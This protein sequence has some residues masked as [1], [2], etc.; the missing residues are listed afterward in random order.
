MVKKPLS[1]AVAVALGGISCAAQADNIW[2]IYEKSLESDPVILRA[3]AQR[4]EAFE[5]ITEARAPLLPQISVTGQYTDTSS[6]RDFRE[7]DGTSATVGLTQ[8]IYR[9]ESWITLDLAEKSA[10]QADVNYNLQLQ[11]LMLRVSQAYFDVLQ[12]MDD[13]EFIA[14]EKRAIERQL[15]QTKQR[16]AVGLTAITDVHEAQAEYDRSVADEIVQLNVLENSYEGLRVLTGLSHRDL[17]VL[18]TE[19]FSPTKPQP[20]SSDGWQ[21]IATDQNLSLAVSRV[22]TDIAKQ[23]IDL[24][25]AGH[26]PTFS[27]FAQHDTSN[28][29]PDFDSGRPDSYDDTTIGVQ[30]SVPIYTGGAISSRERQAQ[31][32]FVATSEQ[33]NET[34][35]EVNRSTINNYNNVI[36]SISAIRAFEQTVVS[37]VSALEATEAGFEV[38]TRTIVDV[39]DATRN[40]YD[41]KRQLSQAR[42]SYI[43]SVLQLK[44]SAGNL[45]EQDLQDINKGLQRPS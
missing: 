10:H 22:A 5:A 16:F 8:E 26:M 13:V 11:N 44:F 20:E 3:A 43:L 12:A 9:Q 33:M 2:Q 36:A 15:E 18:N 35:R 1:F 30:V 45:T 31:H 7:S 39:L 40:L 34:Y 4:Q 24:A 37:R 21:K 17:D 41:A 28:V 25:A 38:G 42:Y 19:L 32:A 29:E 23:N 27:L 6:N 14:A